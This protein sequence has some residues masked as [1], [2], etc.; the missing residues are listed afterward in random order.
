MKKTKNKVVVAGASGYIGNNLLKKLKGK[1]ELVVTQWLVVRGNGLALS[2]LRLEGDDG[3]SEEHDDSQCDQPV[4]FH[5]ALV[6]AEEHHQQ[7]QPAADTG[8]GNGAT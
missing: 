5:V 3:G 7:K 1:V 4:V 6:I 8:D 2:Q